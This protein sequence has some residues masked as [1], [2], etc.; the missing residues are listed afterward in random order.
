MRIRSNLTSLIVALVLSFLMNSAIDAVDA[1]SA[2]GDT[3]K[4]ERLPINAALLKPPAG[5][6]G[7]YDIA[8]TPPDVDFAI[9]PG[10]WSGA[11]LWSSWG[12]AM[13]GS[14]GKFYA[15]LGDH[16]APHG[17]AYVYAIDP[18][19]KTVRRVVDYNAVLGDE[20]RDKS[21]YTPGK[22][23]GAVVEAGDGGI[24]FFGY[25]GSVRQTTAAFG[26]RGD[27]LLRYDSSSGET[28]NLGIGVP[29]CS[30]PVL[31]GHAKSKSLYGLAA[32][33][34]TAD[35][36]SDRFFR[37][38]LAENKLLFVG[39]LKPNQARAMIVTEDGRAYFGHK[40][41]TSGRGV[42]AR[43]EPKAN[44][45]VMTD[46]AIPGGGTLRAAAAPNSAG[47]S[48]CI[49]QEGRLF[50]FDT[51]SEKV[52]ELIDAF[53]APP[54]YIAT[55]KLDPTGRYLYYLPG[56]HGRSSQIGTAVIQ[57]DTK[58]QRRKVI[59]FL[60]EPVLQTAKYHLGGTYGIALSG[61]GSQ[62]FVNFNGGLPGTKQPDFGLCAAALIHI[63]ASERGGP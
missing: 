57:F 37:Y 14:D 49:T 10:Q 55:C 1:V 40:D 39:G 27:W 58:T 33:G 25:R 53:V 17:T 28:K 34:Q 41:E 18:A 63:P 47:V 11:K 50:T 21:K 59:A 38:S 51:K 26:Y 20:A 48:F 42:F 52:T 23:H 2:G 5:L 60:Y 15:S 13:L 6:S 46:T 19:D 43:Y 8:K 24:Y 32:A 35:S 36:D 44:E 30:V 31:I 7:D 56:A 62:L 45:V 9:F 16:D 29:H 12:D 54:T 3:A 61:D 4:L 22:I